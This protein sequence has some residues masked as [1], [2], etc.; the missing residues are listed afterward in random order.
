MS[1][2]LRITAFATS[3]L[4]TLGIAEA[5][6]GNQG[7]ASQLAAAVIMKDSNASIATPILLK[8]PG[9][10][11][12]VPPVWNP[13]INGDFMDLTYSAMFYP[14]DQETLDLVEINAI[15]G[16]H[17]MLDFNANGEADGAGLLWGG[18]SLGVTQDTVGDLG[19]VIA[20]RQAA[21]PQ[22]NHAAD[23]Y[24]YYFTGNTGIGASYIDA[25]MLE[26]GADQIS[27]PMGHSL[28]ALDFGLG[29]TAHR[30]KAPGTFIWSPP[31]NRNEFYFSLS[32][33]SALD[34]NALT[35]N[36]GLKNLA[37]VN[38][39]TVYRMDWTPPTKTTPG[40][41]GN[42]IEH[43]LPARLK[44]DPN[45]DDIDGLA[46]WR[47]STEV[48]VFSTVL[49]HKTNRPQLI[50]YDAGWAPNNAPHHPELKDANG[51]TVMS[52][53]GL[54]QDPNADPQLICFIDPQGG[55]IDA[56]MASMQDTELVHTAVGPTRIGASGCLSGTPPLG[57]PTTIHCQASGLQPNSLVFFASSTALAPALPTWSPVFMGSNGANSSTYEFSAAV[58]ASLQVPEFRFIFLTY[59]SSDGFQQS[60][61][62]EMNTSKY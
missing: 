17:P 38:A 44:L 18:L 32:K 57:E 49:D 15:S 28:I 12:G 1:R 9:D 58:P 46:V 45:V 50:A 13:N 61:M 48:A 54:T 14:E 43:M 39:A 7:L 60:A 25:T 30:Q 52:K 26:Q 37:N 41:W 19:S 55:D 20:A 5:R 42:I 8:G 6:Q 10:H 33:Q 56:T 62:G 23:I 4:I 40:S 59:H 22:I 27:A 34:L 31:A 2:H 21:V 3:A 47:R 16:K 53:F 24:T 51:V 11:S 36:P 29:V 35:N